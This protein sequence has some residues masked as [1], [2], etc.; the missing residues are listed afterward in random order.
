MALSKTTS[1][2]IDRELAQLVKTKAFE[3]AKIR[4]KV[5]TFT[6]MANEIVKKGLQV[7]E[8]EKI[9]PIIHYKDGVEWKPEQKEGFKIGVK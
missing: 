1:L 4:N 8:D 2:P 6:D 5:V 3:Q 7:M 9:K